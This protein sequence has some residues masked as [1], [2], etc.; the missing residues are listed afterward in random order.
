M[1]LGSGIPGKNSSQ[2]PESTKVPDPGVQKAVLR[3]RIQMQIRTF[4]GLLEPDPDLLVRGMD[5]DLDPSI[6]KQK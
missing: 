1:G 5:P 6:I 3:I 2:I 4:L